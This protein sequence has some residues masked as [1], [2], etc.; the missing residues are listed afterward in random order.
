[1]L[2]GDLSDN[3][4]YHQV[5]KG[6]M[7][8]A[9]L[10]QY[11][12]FWYGRYGNDIL[13]IARKGDG[14]R[15]FFALLKNRANRVWNLKCEEVN[16]QSICFLDFQLIKDRHF[17]C[18]SQLAYRLH[19]KV[20]NQSVPLGCNSM[21]EQH[22]W[23][24][25]EIHRIARR[26]S[27]YSFFRDDAQTTFMRWSNFNLRSSL[28]DLCLPSIFNKYIHKS[29]SDR[30]IRPQTFWL[31]LPYHSGF[32][33]KAVRLCIS[34]LLAQWKHILVG[35]VGEFDVRIAYKSYF[36]SLLSKMNTRNDRSV[37]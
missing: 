28:N 17:H 12:I 26:S 18:S 33:D 23:P 24:I 10:R 9:A 29:T 16:S 13:C 1:M 21:H 22:S 19:R 34:E 30:S 35:L 25:A 37:R 4:F 31:V 11:G 8:E 5:E 15:K 20:S 36:P 7:S 2:S 27:C 3:S 32:R 6:L 14:V